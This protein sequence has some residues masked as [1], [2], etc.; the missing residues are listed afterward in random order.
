MSSFFEALDYDEWRQELIENLPRKLLTH[1][2]NIRI[3]DKKLTYAWYSTTYNVSF[4]DIWDH[5]ITCPQDTPPLEVLE[6]WM[7]HSTPLDEKEKKQESFWVIN[8]DLG[9]NA[10]IYRGTYMLQHKVKNGE[11]PHPI[12][13]EKHFNVEHKGAILTV[14]SKYPCPSP[15]TALSYGV[16]F[17]AENV[18]PLF[19]YDTDMCITFKDPHPLL[20]GH[21]D[22]LTRLL[23]Q[24]NHPYTQIFT[25]AEC[26]FG[27]ES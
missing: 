8:E 26:S 1:A 15:S 24:G 20:L 5:R 14:T 2:S 6:R 10:V 27:G 4:D 18:D 12:S 17:F 9:W 16:K 21:K 23:E 19:T 25:L 7:A 3:H 13:F 22:T 11:T